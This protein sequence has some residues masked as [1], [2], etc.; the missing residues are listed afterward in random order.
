MRRVLF[1]GSKKI[2]LSCLKE[3]YNL[4][5]DSLIG[6]VTINDEDDTRSEFKNIQK[7]CK[8]NNIPVS[9]APSKQQSEDIIL[10]YKPDICFVIGWYWL[11]SEKTLNKV[12]NGFLGIHNSLLPLYKGGSPL[13]WQLINGEEEVGVSMFTLTKGVD[14]GDLWFQQKVKINNIDNI[15]DVLLKI[16]SQTIKNFKLYYLDIIKGKKSPTPQPNITE[17]YCAQRIPG[18]GLVDWKKSS[19]EISNFIRAQSKPY[20]GAYSFY[21]EQKLIFWDVVLNKTTYYGTPGQI[22]KISNKGIDIICGDNKTITVKKIN[23]NGK[24]MII[25][26]LIKTLKT[27]LK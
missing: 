12:P 24:D 9:I 19:I 6:V 13:V 1:V 16:E 26:D 14:N 10:S 4:S 15:N 18:D 27:R 20:P 7:F 8:K 2:G 17:S 5:K 22:V 25:N 21:K 11:I 3:M 23:Y